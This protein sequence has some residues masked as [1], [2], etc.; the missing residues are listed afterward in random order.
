MS[1]LSRGKE[2]EEEE[3]EEEG[4]LYSLVCCNA[5]HFNAKGGGGGTYL[6]LS[7]SSSCGIKN[8]GGINTFR[9]SFST[10]LSPPPSL[11]VSRRSSVAVVSSH[12]AFYSADSAR[13]HA[14]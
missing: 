8:C 12:R 2:E 5:E 3:E 10:V 7:L 6:S 14:C 11:F 13:D 4:K 9:F 1:N